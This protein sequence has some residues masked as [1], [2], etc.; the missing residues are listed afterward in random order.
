MSQGIIATFDPKSSGIIS[1]ILSDLV[2]E[3][4][5]R[6]M[7]DQQVVSH[8]TILAGEKMDMSA[9]S[10]VIHEVSEIFHPFSIDVGSIAYF[11]S[12]QVL[13]LNPNESGD[14]RAL[15]KEMSNRMAK[16]DH[17][18]TL[19]PDEPWIPHITLAIE[20]SY[21]NIGPAIQIVQRHLDLQERQPFRLRVESIA[22]FQYPP[23]R[24]LD[25]AR[26][27]GKR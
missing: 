6:F 5:N 24:V 4:L 3:S 10:Q 27:D 11:P 21:A 9:A 8:L 14:L 26:L 7:L 16:R 20:L 1:R 17:S 18:F 25:K 13:F 23:F 19:I 2:N 15:H 12:T 22:Y